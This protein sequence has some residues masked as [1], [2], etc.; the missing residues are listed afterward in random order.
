MAL[1]GR[2][3]AAKPVVERVAGASAEGSA[4]LQGVAELVTSVAPS[5]VALRVASP[6]GERFGS[7]VVIRSDGHVLVNAHVVE[8]ATAI[9]LVASDGRSFSGR[10]VGS[11]PEADLAVIAVSDSDLAPAVLGSSAAL[12]PGELVVVVGGRHR[13]QG[14]LSVTTGVVAGL[15]QVMKVGQ[16]PFYDVVTTDAEISSR[17]SGGPLLDRQGAVVG[18]TAQ[19]APADSDEA[20]A[21]VIP[22]DR[23]RK[24]AEQLI[25]EGSVGY[26]WL[27]LSGTDV[28]PSTAAR[29]AVNRG[30]VIRTIEPR[31]PADR[32]GLRVEDVITA[33]EASLIATTDDLT[34]LVRRHGPG[35]EIQL[36][37]VRSGIPRTVRVR[38]DRTP[39][40]PPLR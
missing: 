15:G 6:S 3:E 38:L 7:G 35:E 31:S 12:R 19:M 27:G 33:V 2:F 4:G 26:S 36:T 16:R 29:H 23:A 17:A 25:A 32:S 30:S 34:M 13:P 14:S 39:G 10:F 18:I 20:S 40:T 1:T 22:I 11:D 5:V 28:D 24:V 37:V 9:Q 8:G 21:V